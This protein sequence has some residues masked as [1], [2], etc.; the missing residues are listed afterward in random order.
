[1][2]RPAFGIVLVVSSKISMMNTLQHNESR[3]NS[4]EATR[5]S[6]APDI[7]QPESWLDEDNTFLEGLYLEPIP[8]EDE[9]V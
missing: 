9:V 5:S 7:D 4:T 6:R 3:E 8:Q 1:M 2:G